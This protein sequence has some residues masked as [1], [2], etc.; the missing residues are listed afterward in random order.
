MREWKK[1]STTGL[2]KRGRGYR[3]GETHHNA[4]L[5]D[6]DVELIRLLRE[7]GMKLKEIAKKFE[8]TPECISQIANYKTRSQVGM[9][10]NKVFEQMKT[11]EKLSRTAKTKRGPGYRIGETHHNAKLTD[12]EV[13]LIRAIRK[14]G[15][16]IVDI[17]KRFKCTPSHISSITN[18][19]IRKVRLKFLNNEK[20]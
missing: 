7:G 2:S 12:H 17:A 10:E 4:K 16:K 1:V 18:N 8:C 14:N 19:K 20:E 13:K 6:H 5:T 9:A 15:V 3:V 11:Y